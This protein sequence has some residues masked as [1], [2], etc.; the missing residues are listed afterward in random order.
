MTA[1][2]VRD[3]IAAE[4]AQRGMSQLRAAELSG[5][6]QANISR[7]LRSD[8]VSIPPTAFKL[9]DALGLEVTLQPRS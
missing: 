6:E 4:M 5:L 2:E 3:A 9:L 8:P 1:R 7:Y